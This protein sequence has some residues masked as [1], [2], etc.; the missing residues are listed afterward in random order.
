MP[1]RS[2]RDFYHDEVHKPHVHEFPATSTL[3]PY[4]TQEVGHSVLIM[5]LL[6]PICWPQ[7]MGIGLIST[8]W[9][10]DTTPGK[11]TCK[12]ISQECPAFSEGLLLLA[13]PFM[14]VA[15][16]SRP[17]ATPE[18]VLVCCTKKEKY[19]FLCVYGNSTACFTSPLSFF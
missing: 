1:E 16:A 5:A 17:V 6:L 19:I 14:P 3:R 15:P 18:G 12:T 4:G 2:Y 8:V 10:C 13:P 9:L 11:P 7:S